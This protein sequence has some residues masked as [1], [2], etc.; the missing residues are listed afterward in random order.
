MRDIEL[1]WRRFGV[2]VLE[3]G[4]R[5]ECAAWRVYEVRFEGVPG[6]RGCQRQWTHMY[7][8][9]TPCLGETELFMRRLHDA[10]AQADDLELH[11]CPVPVVP[12]LLIGDEVPEPFRKD[13]LGQRTRRVSRSRQSSR[14]TEGRRACR[15]NVLHHF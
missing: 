9:W 6:G 3:Y 10:D 14:V 2:P 8:Y 13:N 15:L 11:L 4:N 7:T 5:L 12:D 1:Y